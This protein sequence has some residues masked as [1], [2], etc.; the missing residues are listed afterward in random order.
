MKK[1]LLIGFIAVAI[2]PMQVGAYG[3]ETHAA[4]TME[5]ARFYNQFYPEHAFTQ[6]EM[7]VLASGAI[8]EDDGTRP[9]NH[10]YDPI[11]K[12][13][14]TYLGQHMPSK[15]WV[16]DS[17]AQA[18]IVNNA[19]ALVLSPDDYNS[20]DF[21]WRRA[22][23]DYAR[24]K[25]ERGLEGLGH[26]LHLVEDLTV[27]AHVRNDAHPPKDSFG[28]RIGDDDPYELWS[29]KFNTK[30][31]NILVHLGGKRPI[32]GLGSLNKYF[33]ELATYTNMNFF[34]KDTINFEGFGLPEL[35]SLKI[36]NNG[37]L[38]FYRNGDGAIVAV[39]AASPVKDLD[40]RMTTDEER[41][42]QSTWDRLSPR[43]VQYGAGVVDL[44]FSEVE[45]LKKDP[46]FK[47]TEQKSLLG[48]F[49]DSVGENVGALVAGAPQ[50]QPVV[51]ARVATIPVSDD[52]VATEDP[53]PVLEPIHFPS[54]EVAE[55]PVVSPPKEPVIIKEFKKPLTT[56]GG[57]DEGAVVDSEDPVIEEVPVIESEPIVEP[58]VSEPEPTPEPI[59][60]IDIISPAATVDLRAEASSDRVVLLKWTAPGDDDEVGAAVSYE[61]RYST[62]LITEENWLS[63][64]L[65]ESVSVPGVAG[66]GEKFE[67]SGFAPMTTYYFA[68]KA[69]DETGNES[70]LSNIASTKTLIAPPDHLVISEI[71]P[72]MTGADTNEFVELYNPTDEPISISGYSL[73]YLTG[74]AAS[75]ASI[76]KKNFTVGAI[77]PAKGFYLIG[78][79][80]NPNADMAW[81]EQLHNTGAT[82]LLVNDQVAIATTDDVNIVDKVSYGTGAGLFVPEGL[83]APLP[84]EG[85][86]LERK[87]FIAGVC[88]PATGDGE[89]RGNGCDVNDNNSDFEVGIMPK[90]QRLANLIEPRTAPP[91]ISN[92]PAVLSYN[93]A[94][95]QLVF[96][97]QPVKDISGSSSGMIYRIM[98]VSNPDASIQLYSGTALTFAKT[99]DEIGREYK[100]TI[101][102]VDKDGLSSELTELSVAVPG[103][104]K[105]LSFFSEDNASGSLSYFARLAWDSYP[106]VPI[107]TGRWHLAVFY[108]NKDAEKIANLGQSNIGYNWG[109]SLS[110]P[111]SFKTSYANCLG[112]GTKGA[113]LILPDDAVH[114]SPFF[115]GARSQAI[116]LG[117]LRDK[118]LTLS[119][120]DQTFNGVEPVPGK[121][122][123]TV[124]YYFYV[125]GG[126]LNSDQRL[127]AVDKTRYYLSE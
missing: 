93:P 33:D 4:I 11:H 120:S 116:D 35:Q 52:V 34:S 67:V 7:R 18:G 48:Q 95:T 45:K 26:V 36:E 58:E 70:S 123:I 99:I 43:A 32:S 103:Y 126:N 114:C 92:E 22:I 122:F 14:L 98:D 1:L 91:T 106:F 83:S 73:Q 82:V 85:K 2:M 118:A 56:S 62:D 71:F 94:T 78:M 28:E 124:A 84:G 119:I 72:D 110:M 75:L 107:G 10:F 24:G 54:D 86:S 102:A 13:G 44:F 53:E 3:V 59:P 31:I 81:S 42:S 109:T 30:N 40:I 27:P 12:T 87:A 111:S 69:K 51:I 55:A 19:L 60:D 77:V 117:L 76:T 74:S 127:I 90:G 46:K 17:V 104:L 38:N 39:G 9:L 100:A 89:F 8:D 105:E 88:A 113:S 20:T 41:V 21:T 66:G 125:D 80:G 50:P 25:T 112:T 6:L 15:S 64:T 108:Y 5:I 29:H 37:K 68:L 63:G 101:Q 121:D 57:G 65:I 61:V 47:I 115:G 23:E 16:Q 96:S 79:W 49:I 97:W